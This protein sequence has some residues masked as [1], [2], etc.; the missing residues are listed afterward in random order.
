MFNKD[1]VK[2]LAYKECWA[3]ARAKF[4][5]GEVLEIEECRE[6]TDA[7]VGIA[8]KRMNVKMESGTMKIADTLH[9]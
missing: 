5:D 7:L 2:L 6:E 8:I 1:M 4:E 9:N 3:E